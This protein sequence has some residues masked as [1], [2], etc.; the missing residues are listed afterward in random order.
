MKAYRTFEEYMYDKYYDKIHFQINGF[1]CQKKSSAF[2]CT[3]IIPDVNRFELEDYHIMGVTYKSTGGDVLNF[4]LSINA[5]VNV[6]GKSRYEYESDTK[7]IWLSV[8]CESILRNG[9]QNLKFLQVEEYSKEKYDKERNIDHYLVPYLYSDDADSIAEDFLRRHCPQ[10]LQIAMPLPIDEVVRNLGMQAYY[11]PLGNNI[12]GKTYFE[13]SNV[14]VY[15]D[16]TCQETVEISVSPGT[17][18][19]NPNVFFINAPK[20]IRFNDEEHPEMTEYALDHV[21]E[22]CFLFTSV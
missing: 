18:L 14:T 1:L 19:V 4:R 13:A 17:M 10:A 7:S 3:N 16:N 12:F 15:T 6:Y 5:D 11:A 20:Y 2:L 9:L 22:C 8:Y 21:D